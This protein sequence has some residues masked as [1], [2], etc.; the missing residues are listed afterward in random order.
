MAASNGGFVGVRSGLMMYESRRAKLL[1]F[2]RFVQRLAMHGLVAIS[3]LLF[4]LGIGMVGYRHYE[5]MSW[6]DGYV[7]ASMLLSGMGPIET[8]LS[9]GGKIFAGTY[10]LYSGLVFIIVTGIIVAPV[11]H[12]FLHYLHIES[13][14]DGDAS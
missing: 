9:D 8:H 1:P 5:H 13:E 4:S 14:K 10:A 11:L 7:N 12:R 6:T 3:A 2:R